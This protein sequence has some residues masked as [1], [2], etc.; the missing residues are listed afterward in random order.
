MLGASAFW[1]KIRQGQLLGK[2]VKVSEHQLP[3]VHQAAL[4]A[5]ERLCMRKPDVF[6]IQ[7]P[8]INAYATGFLDDRKTVVLHSALVEAMDEDELLSIIGH[9]FSHIKCDH[10]NW[11]VLTNT[12]ENVAKIPIVSDIIGFIFLLWSRKCE[13]T[14]DRGG[15]LS[16]RNLKAST[17]AL[18]KLAVGKQLFE[19]M[20]LDALLEQKKD[21]DASDTSR[22]SELFETHPHIINRIHELKKFY[23]SDLYTKL[24][25]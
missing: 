1:I 24:T 12:A 5:S 22:L 8:I 18:A 7:S 25:A 9:E 21:V 23:E 11:I 15:L 6:V 4:V 20:N 10:T 13:Y 3:E 2:G 14:C 17:S 16:S 19:R